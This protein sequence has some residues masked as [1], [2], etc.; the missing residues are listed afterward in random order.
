M[1][2]T[3]PSIGCQLTRTA[4]SS[5]PVP[6]TCTV[7]TPGRTATLSIRATV[8]VLERPIVVPQPRAG[9]PVLGTPPP[10]AGLAVP[11]P[12]NAEPI[13]IALTSL[14]QNVDA[15]ATAPYFGC[16]VPDTFSLDQLFTEATPLPAALPLFVTDIGGL[17]LLG[18][19]RKRKAQAVA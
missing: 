19:R 10:E 15:F 11:D 9:E 7:E 8:A 3:A 16:T 14:D 4:S 5:A 2:P 6:V 17:G 18:W 1:Y 12:R 13:R